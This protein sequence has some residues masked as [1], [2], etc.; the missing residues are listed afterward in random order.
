MDDVLL[1]RLALFASL[2]GLLLIFIIMPKYEPVDAHFLFSDDSNSFLKGNI[3][4]ISYNN[5]SGW[6]FIEI[7]SC[8]TFNSFYKGSLDKVR[9]DV[10]FVQGSFYNDVFSVENYK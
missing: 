8:R 9:G 6:S 3:S 5:D 10:I 2:A 7:Y 4:R 1:E